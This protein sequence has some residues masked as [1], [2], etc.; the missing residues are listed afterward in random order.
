MSQKAYLEVESGKIYTV[1]PYSNEA[2]YISWVE[3]PYEL[4]GGSI[5]KD[6]LQ[7]LIKKGAWIEL[8]KDGAE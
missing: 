1:V 2:V 8:E 5:T 6:Y 3:K 7:L 4:D